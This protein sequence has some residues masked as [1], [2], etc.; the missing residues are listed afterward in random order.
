[1]NRIK[2]LPKPPCRMTHF[3][4]T[5]VTINFSTSLPEFK[6]GVKIELQR[7]KIINNNDTH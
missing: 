3:F 5:F 7:D 1:M 4:L 6:D 2:L